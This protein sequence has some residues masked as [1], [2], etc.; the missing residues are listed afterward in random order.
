MRTETVV[1][2]CFVSN[3][4]FIAGTQHWH[5]HGKI[6]HY[7]CLCF[8]ISWQWYPPHWSTSTASVGPKDEST[9]V[10][11]NETVKHGK[12]RFRKVLN[13]VI[14]TL[15][16]LRFEMYSQEFKCITI[17]SVHTPFQCA[18]S[19]RLVGSTMVMFLIQPAILRQSKCGDNVSLPLRAWHNASKLIPYMSSM[20]ESVALSC[21]CV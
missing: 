18:A 11:N 2:I 8:V 16:Y 4:M 20:L 12:P 14:M 1:A 10:P 3:E 7:F 6:Y 5:T 15:H 17:A 13:S 19:R 9:K 21:A